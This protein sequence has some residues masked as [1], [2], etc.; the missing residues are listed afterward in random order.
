MRRRTKASI[1]VVHV[2]SY[3]RYSPEMR[4]ESEISPSKPSAPQLPLDRDLVGAIR[5]R[6]EQCD[7]DGIDSALGERR[8]RLGQAREVD[9]Q[10]DLAVCEHALG[11]GGTQVAGN[12]RRRRL[13]E[14]VVG[15]VAIAAAHLE[16]IAEAAGRDQPDGGTAPLEQRIQADGGAVQEERRRGDALRAERGLD[17][18]H[19]PALGCIG[20]GRLLAHH[21]LARAVIAPHEIRERPTHVDAQKRCHAAGGYAAAAPLSCAGRTRFAHSLW[22]EHSFG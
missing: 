22:L 17:R 19:D 7:R 4:C 18:A 21:D 14:E 1:T 8:E 16:H 11:D 6:V 9:R 2:R 3:S 20:P 13:P 10:V 15:V 12:E 5:V